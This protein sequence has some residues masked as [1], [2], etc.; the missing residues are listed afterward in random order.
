MG[1]HLVRAAAAAV[2]RLRQH[3]HLARDGGQRLR[4]RC[5]CWL[6]AAVPVP[7]PHTAAHSRVDAVALCRVVAARDTG[8]QIIAGLHFDT[9]AAGFAL[10]DTPDGRIQ[11]Y[12]KRHPVPG[13]EDRYTPGR[14]S[15]WLG[16]G[17]A[18]EICKDMDFPGTI[19][20]DAAKGVRLMGV[21][22]GD[23]GI[24]RWQHGIMTVMRGVED[25]FAMVSPAHDGL[26]MIISDAQGRLLA[27]TRT[28][29]TGLT[30]AIAD[31]PLGPGPT[32]YTRIGDL[33]P[34]LCAIASLMLGAG[35]AI[36]RWFPGRPASSGRE[37]A[38][39][40]ECPAEH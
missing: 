5:K 20:R 18:V 10:S 40:A 37:G 2:A 27:A 17:R 12:V 23:M 8:A 9:P 28:A 32:L 29:P 21:P 1:T 16:G 19:R 15:G 6:C 30:M 31:L 14:A 24:D 39:A 25:G 13:L 33:F 26:V 4:C 35:L 22:A 7:P 38:H 34:W 36:R 11:R 3:T